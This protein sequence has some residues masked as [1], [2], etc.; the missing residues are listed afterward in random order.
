[1]SGYLPKS[2]SPSAS[3]GALITERREQSPQ[4][5]AFG[6]KKNG[7]YQRLTWDDVGKRIDAIGAG[8]LTAMDLDDD[9]RITIVGNAS[10]EW[11]L[12][13]FAALSV[14]LQTVPV[15]A[16][17]LY[18]EVAFMH[19]DTAAVLAIV[20][21][22]GQLEK[23]RKA[24]KGAEFRE[25]SIAKDDVKVAHIVVINP[26]G[27]EPA[28]DWESLEALEARGRDQLDATKDE[29]AR[30]LAKKG[31]DDVATFTYTSGTTGVPKAVIQTHE[32]MLSMLE[33]VDELGLFHTASR[34]HG[35]FL[36]LPPAHSFGRLI[37]LAGP[38]L[39]APLILSAVPTLVDDLVASPPGFFPSAPRVYEKMQA[40]IE[41][42]VESAPPLR[43]AIFRWARSVGEKTIEPRSKGKDLS[44][45]LGLQAKIANK[46][47]WSKL[48]AKLGL[49]NT[50]LLLSGSAPLSPH[51]HR[52]FLSLGFNLMEAYGLTET[53]PGL[54]SNHPE[55]FRVG[56]VGK[57][58]PNVDIQIADDG[59]I[60]AKGPNIT[61]G[62]LNRPDATAEIFDDDG[63]F[64]TGDLGKLEDG[65]L[66]IT[67]RKKELIK[68]SGGKYVAPAKIEEHIKRHRLIQEGVVIGDGHNYCV[69]LIALDEEE[70][71]DWAKSNGISSADARDKARAEVETHFKDVNADLA[72]FE[73]IKKFRLVD[74]SF[75]VENQMLTASLKVRRNKVTE[76]Y[77][78]L[79]DEMYAK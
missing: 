74:E 39:G 24:Q 28:D 73:T 72:S 79:I 14:G 2:I 11:M 10:L 22:K 19:A 26:D 61:Q 40:K 25:R 64:L 71:A 34:L 27:I 75:T 43:Q 15:Y 65:F 38:F 51:V 45:F 47:V 31:R 32:N 37:E 33:A 48:Q 58:F 21:D 59:E 36:F 8:L 78:A 4:A 69:A 44:P 76:K 18:E 53:C 3:L 70:L 35:L 12:C 46:L 68:T 1:M 77:A 17:L 41:A 66:R 55:D 63:W 54:T 5:D 57:P 7:K 50:E 13:D 9:A 16:S 49:Q 67:G 60:M 52:F 62:Y 56:T 30:R 6:V 29:R 23:L 42:T 20:E